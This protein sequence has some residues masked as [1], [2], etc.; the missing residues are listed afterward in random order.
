[1]ATF[2]LYKLYSLAPNPFPT[3]KPNPRKPFQICGL[4]N[5]HFWDTKAPHCIKSVHKHTNIHNISYIQCHCNNIKVFFT[6][7]GTNCYR[8]V[9]FCCESIIKRTIMKTHLACVPLF[10]GSPGVSLRRWQAFA[11]LSEGAIIC[12]RSKSKSTAGPAVRGRTAQCLL[13]HDQA[14]TRKTSYAPAF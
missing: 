11:A 3:H 8:S 1:M 10:S 5:D 2:I 12:T 13:H 9:D 14:R 6:W 7:T 4:F